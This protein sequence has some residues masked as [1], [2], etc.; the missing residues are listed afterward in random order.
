MPFLI[1]GPSIRTTP[2]WVIFS[3]PFITKKKVNLLMRWPRLD[4]ALAMETKSPS[5][6]V[7]NVEQPNFSPCWVEKK[8]KRN[9]NGHSNVWQKAGSCSEGSGVEWRSEAIKTF[10]GCWLLK[11]YSRFDA[12]LN[13]R[14]FNVISVFNNLLMGQLAFA[15]SAHS[16]NFS[17]LMPGTL[18]FNT[19]CE[20]AI[21]ILQNWSQVTV[22]S[23]FWSKTCLTQHET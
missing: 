18:P 10:R 6:A 15:F 1:G 17:L 4:L 7:I 12:S 22:K 5:E 13:Q 9:S 14:S 2:A 8:A 3:M 20:L 16:S 11:A 19:R 23:L 21:T